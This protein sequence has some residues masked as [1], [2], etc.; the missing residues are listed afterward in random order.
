[1][2]WVADGFETVDDLATATICVLQGTTLELNLADRLPDS[3][4]VPFE[5]NETLQAAFIE[6]R[7]DGW[8]S[9]KSQLASRRAVFP[10][11]AGGPESLTILD[12]TF[13][14]PGR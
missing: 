9:D 7:C 5:D 14:S 11:D 4:V 2:V 12:E 8:T 6:E 3:E 10:E 1:M 13:S